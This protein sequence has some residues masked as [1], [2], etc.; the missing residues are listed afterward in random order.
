[1]IKLNF[2]EEISEGN[3]NVFVYKTKSDLKGPSSKQGVPFYNPTM[4]LNRDISIIV[5][6]HLLDSLKRKII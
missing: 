1:M 2:F 6:Q 3:T 5:C 4:Q